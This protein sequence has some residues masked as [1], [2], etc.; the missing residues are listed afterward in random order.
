MM[1]DSSWWHPSVWQLAQTTVAT[2]FFLC[3][4]CCL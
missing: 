2:A 3:I 4:K 1:K